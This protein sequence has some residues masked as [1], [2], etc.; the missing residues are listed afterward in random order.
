VLGPQRPDQLLAPH[1]ALTVEQQVGEQERDLLA[2]Q[3]PG[4]LLAVDLDG[5]PATKLDSGSLGRGSPPETFW[6]RI[7]NGGTASCRA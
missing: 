4:Q 6:K 7:D 3:T 2:T 5:Q 1:Q